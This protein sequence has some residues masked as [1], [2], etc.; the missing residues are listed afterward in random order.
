MAEGV[1][2]VGIK[3]ARFKPITIVTGPTTIAGKILLIT[4]MPQSLTTNA[5]MP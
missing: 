1:T 4:L 5:K 3:P 2:Y